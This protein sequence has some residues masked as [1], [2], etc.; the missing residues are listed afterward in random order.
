MSTYNTH[1][2]WPH[3]ASV[4]VHVGRA[5]EITVQ[6]YLFNSYC[7][8][9]LCLF[10]VTSNLDVSIVFSFWL[11]HN[12]CIH[13]WSMLWLYVSLCGYLCVG[14]GT[15]V[16]MCGDH[17]KVLQ[18]FCSIILLHSI[19]L[20]QGLSLDLELGCQ[21]AS[22][23]DAPISAPPQL[24]GHRRPH[25]RLAFYV[26]PKDLN[27]GLYNV[28]LPVSSVR[29]WYIHTWVIIISEYLPSLSPQTMVIFFC[30]DS[31]KNIFWK[32]IILLT[33]ATLLYCRTPELNS[34]SDCSFALISPFSLL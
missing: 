13:L 17:R 7:H 30:S 19:P 11:V 16:H 25:P 10:L 3:A 33:V 9:A 2:P 6:G 27:L 1:S 24:S 15:C 18:V 20:W 21:S 29:Y 12:N 5:L 31:I 4:K 26:G 14:A 28:I 34:L 23:R 8:Q 22:P 32:H